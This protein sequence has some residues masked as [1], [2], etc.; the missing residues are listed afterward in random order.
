MKIIRVLLLLIILAFILTSCNAVSPNHPSNSQLQPSV[1]SNEALSPFTQFENLKKRGETG[2]NSEQVDNILRSYGIYDRVLA[3]IPKEDYIEDVRI[4]GFSIGNKK[5][6]VLLINKG[7]LY[8]YVMFSNNNDK[9]IVDGFTYQNERDKPEYRVEQSS[10]EMRYWLVV[11]HEANHGTGLQIYDESWYNPDG[12]VAGEYPVEGSTLFFPQIIEPGVNTYFSTSAYYY[13]DSKVSLSYS[14]SFEYFYKDNIQDYGFYRFQ[15]KYCPV[16]R[17]NWEY[18]LK[19][20]QLNFISC[21]PAL[22]ESFSTMKHVAT[23]E[24]GILQGYINFYRMRLGDKKITS[25][26]EWEKF[27]GLK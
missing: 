13:G 9:W 5:V 20:K 12:S 8:I 18:D 23:A 15:S 10:D 4:S 22:P 19:T 14:I 11:K 3:K 26:G 6:A 16:I 2:F 25:L 17:E 24:Y 21:D 7:H 27:M 1:K